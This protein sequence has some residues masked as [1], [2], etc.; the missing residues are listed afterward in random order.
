[1][2]PREQPNV[3]GLIEAL[4]QRGIRVIGTEG[5]HPS[6]PGLEKWGPPLSGGRA[7]RQADRPADREPG[8]PAPAQE[9]VS[10]ADLRPRRGGSTLVVDHSVRSGQSVISEH[11]D[12]VVIGSVASGAEMMAGGSIHVYGT[13]RG[14]AVAGV[15][16]NSR[17][18]H[19]LPQASKPSCWRSTACIAPPTTSSRP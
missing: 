12:V 7:G 1:M 6:W 3:A 14:R 13:L 8:A 16:G 5:A 19:F 11:G 2:L 10:P 17:R 9:A 18:P 15:S 4:R